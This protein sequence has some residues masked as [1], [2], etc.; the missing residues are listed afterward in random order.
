M[1]S[2]AEMLRPH[3][4]ADVPINIQINMD[5]FLKRINVIRTMWGQPM[6]V[7]SGYRTA[8]DQRRINPKAIDTSKHL[9]GKA[10]DILDVSGDLNA[11]LKRGEWM[12][13][14]N[15]LWCE[16][17]QGNWQHFQSEPPKS[18]HRWFNP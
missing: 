11:W 10:I 18:G 14:D 17:R 2:F 1:I 16:E 13:E 6:H 8:V 3:S 5:D 4:I 15:G 7:T 9:I 12:L